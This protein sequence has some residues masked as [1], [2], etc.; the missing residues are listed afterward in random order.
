MKSSG[1]FRF[2]RGSFRRDVIA[3]IKSIDLVMMYIHALGYQFIDFYVNVYRLS[4]FVAAVL[5]N[6][7][8]CGPYD[9]LFLT[10][11]QS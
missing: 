4:L 3:L 7:I 1:H 2:R 9:N 5:W 6:I 10:V 8:E 11:M